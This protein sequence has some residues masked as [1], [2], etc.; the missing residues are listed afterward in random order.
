VGRYLGTFADLAGY[1][2]S[3]SGASSRVVKRA[4]HVSCIGNFRWSRNRVASDEPVR[5]RRVVRDDH[6]RHRAGTQNRHGVHA[7]WHNDAETAV[8]FWRREVKPSRERRT[9]AYARH[10]N[11]VAS[12]R[13]PGPGSGTAADGRS[14]AHRARGIRVRTRRTCAWRRR[15]NHA[16]G[17]ARAR[18]ARAADA[19]LVGARSVRRRGARRQV[20]TLRE[21]RRIRR[22][23]AR[24][25]VWGRGDVRQGRK[26]R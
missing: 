3:G 17:V 2:K 16:G 23:C 8:H 7:R 21:P 18:L 22:R 24:D 11:V 15:A 20:W 5:K 14:K 13:A 19:S 12:R 9:R 6:Q 1:P 10:G 26:E 4:S 25:C